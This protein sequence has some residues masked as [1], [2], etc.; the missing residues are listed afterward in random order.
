MTVGA[1]VAIYLALGVACASVFVWA[2]KTATD[3]DNP[4]F[5][6]DA[7]VQAA[8]RSAED[9]VG[10]FPGGMVGALLLVVLAWPAAVALFIRSKAGRH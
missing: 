1:V 7:E 4:E 9:A 10:G 3:P 5:T 6:E 2:I 8:T